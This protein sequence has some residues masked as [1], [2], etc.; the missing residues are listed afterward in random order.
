[1]KEFL[2]DIKQAE[3]A[4]QWHFVKPNPMK[5]RERTYG[6]LKI[7]PMKDC[8]TNPMKGTAHSRI[9]DRITPGKISLHIPFFLLRL[10]MGWMEK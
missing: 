10:D 1:M 6:V 8:E 3:N 7:N 5:G 4:P 2:G 9:A